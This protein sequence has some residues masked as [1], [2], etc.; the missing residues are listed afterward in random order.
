MKYLLLAALFLGLFS[1]PTEAR[2]RHHHK[3]RHMHLVA[4]PAMHQ[5]CNILFPC[6]IAKAMLAPV[7]AIVSGLQHVADEASVIVAH[8]AGCPARQFCACGAAVRVFGQPVRSLWLAANWYRF[9][10]VALENAAPGM[11][12]VHPHHVFVLEAALGGGRW[13]VYDANSGR[14]LTRVHT[15]SIAGWKIV[16]PRS[17]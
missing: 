5:D 15:R 6:E 8:P 2:H 12:A 17:G 14:H 1:G 7:H 4:S 9:P 3:H 16:D 13:R 10:R 11:V